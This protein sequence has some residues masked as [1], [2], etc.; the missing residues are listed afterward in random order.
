MKTKTYLILLI[1]I[2]AASCTSLQQSTVNDDIYYSP[3]DQ[4]IVENNI[5]ANKLQNNNIK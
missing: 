1:A 5:S 2:F 4:V 3:K